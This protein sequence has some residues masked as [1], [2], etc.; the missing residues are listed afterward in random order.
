MKRIIVGSHNLSLPA[1]RLSFISHLT[2]VILIITTLAF[3]GCGKHKKSSSPPTNIGGGYTLVVSGGTLN[4]G[5]GVNGLVVL[6]TLR[7]SSGAGPGGA[8]G[9]KIKITG[10]GINTALEADYIVSVF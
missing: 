3:S 9:W 7:N 4:D 2:F 1:D 10:P 8:A 5:S 6:A